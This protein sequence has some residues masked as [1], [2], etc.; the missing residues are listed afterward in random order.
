MAKKM[1]KRK[2]WKPTDGMEPGTLSLDRWADENRAQHRALLLYAMQHEGKA[3]SNVHRSKAAV[4]R[5]TSHSQVTMYKWSNKYKWEDRI[6]NVVDAEGMAVAMYRTQY[7]DEHGKLDLP[8]IMDKVIVPISTVARTSDERFNSEADVLL[9]Q[10]KMKAESAVRAEQAVLHQAQ[11]RRLAERQKVEQFRQ[12]L[13]ATIGESARL[14][15]ERKL[16]ISAKDIPVL[17]SAR[18]DLANWLTSADD[19]QLDGRA[20][21]ESAR[22]KHARDT[23]K[24]LVEAMWQDLEEMRTILSTMRTRRDAPSLELTQSNYTEMRQQAEQQAKSEPV[25]IDVVSND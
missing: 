19:R 6:A 9:A 12:L 1:P 2:K 13:D 14:L 18:Q 11:E 5:A 22:V 24:D 20:G 10:A 21:V 23:G 25:V 4:G 3:Q 15:K 16:K 8:H 17:I 7:L